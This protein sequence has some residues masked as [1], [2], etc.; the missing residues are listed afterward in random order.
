MAKGVESETLPKNHP[1]DDCRLNDPEL[2]L[3][4]PRNY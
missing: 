1:L 3:F 4:L 2:H